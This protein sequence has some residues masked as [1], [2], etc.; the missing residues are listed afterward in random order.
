MVVKVLELLVVE[1]R[2]TIFVVG[3]DKARPRQMKS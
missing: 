3:L 1:P 2:M